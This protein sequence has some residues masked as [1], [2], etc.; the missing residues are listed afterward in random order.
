MCQFTITA[1]TTY[2]KQSSIKEH[3]FILLQFCRLEVKN[4]FQGHQ[5]QFSLKTLKENPFFAFS[6]RQN[7]PLYFSLACVTFAH[8]SNFSFFF[9]SLYL[10][11]LRQS[12]C[13][14]LIR[15]FAIVLSLP[16]EST[17]IISPFQNP[18]LNFRRVPLSYK[19]TQSQILEFRMCS[20]CRRENILQPIR[21]TTNLM[22]NLILDML[23]GVQKDQCLK[24]VHSP[25][26]PVDPFHYNTAVNN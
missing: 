8:H 19:V 20:F 9:L 17:K 11:L 4:L 21:S 5:F 3:T 13:L 23:H 6:S 1:I 2:H 24:L 12:S 26:V 16:I 14:S 10:L 7:L 25:A 15:D 22:L 18:Q